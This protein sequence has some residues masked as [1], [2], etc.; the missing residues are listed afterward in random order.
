MEKKSYFI[1]HSK[2][3]ET[4]FLQ[5]YMSVFELITSPQLE[6]NTENKGK[7]FAARKST[8]LGF[9]V[10]QAFIYHPSTV[11]PSKQYLQESF[12]VSL[13]KLNNFL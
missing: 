6:S 9:K 2:K 3:Q 12:W 13:I 11:S 8:T 7:P 4:K 1:L 5:A 10:L